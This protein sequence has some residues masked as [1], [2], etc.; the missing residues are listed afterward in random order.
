[1]KKSLRERKKGELGNS[2]LRLV[3]NNFQGLV[4]KIGVDIKALLFES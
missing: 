1:L 4:E 3:A 2:L